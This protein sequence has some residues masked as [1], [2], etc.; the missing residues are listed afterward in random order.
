MF[1][2]LLPGE[3]CLGLL[4][5][6]AMVVQCLPH[7]TTGIEI[8]GQLAGYIGPICVQSLHRL[9]HQP[10]EPAAAVVQ[11]LVDHLPHQV[12]IELIVPTREIVP[13]TDEAAAQEFVQSLQRGLLPLPPRLLQHIEVEGTSDDGSDSGRLAGQGREPL[14]ARLDNLAYR[15][16]NG[17]AGQPRLLDPL[18]A[19]KPHLFL[20]KERPQGLQ[21]EEGVPFCLTVDA[22]HEG[23]ARA[24]HPAGQSLTRET[25][26]FQPRRQSASLQLERQP[27]QRVI[28]ADFLAPVGG[29]QQGGRFGQTAGQIV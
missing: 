7:L 1:L 28:G 4:G 2:S 23:I 27:V 18:P 6:Q 21:R 15:G 12:V 26:Q 9:A 13:L 16:R 8:M 3:Q 17:Q 14:Q 5:G 20:L 29:D 10:V 22:P 25:T 24:S 19:D 11:S